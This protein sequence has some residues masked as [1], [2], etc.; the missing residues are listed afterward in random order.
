MLRGDWFIHC[1]HG[2]AAA[3]A[4]DADWSALLAIIPGTY[5]EMIRDPFLYII[6]HMIGPFSLG[7]FANRRLMCYDGPKSLFYLSCANPELD[8]VPYD[9][10]FTVGVASGRLFPLRQYGHRRIVSYRNIGLL[11][12]PRELMFNGTDYVIIPVRFWKRSGH[13]G[14]VHIGRI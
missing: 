4:V 13:S 12:S 10:S 8:P 6:R 5:L 2:A 3:Q 14:D 7:D 9:G 1:S 11:A